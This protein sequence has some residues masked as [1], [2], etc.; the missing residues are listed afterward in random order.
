MREGRDIPGVRPGGTGESRSGSWSRLDGARS[1]N[2]HLL[3]TTGKICGVTPILDD[4][5]SQ[6]KIID[7]G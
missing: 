4:E 2:G 3:G 5:F 1:A 7:A 6:C